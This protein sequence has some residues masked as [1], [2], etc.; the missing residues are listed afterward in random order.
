MVE[1]FPPVCG[2]NNGLLIA[3]FVGGCD[4]FGAVAFVEIPCAT[5][6]RTMTATSYRLPF[7]IYIYGKIL[8]RFAY[9]PA[10]GLAA[11][12]AS[13]HVM[14]LSWLVLRLLSDY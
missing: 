5:A 8:A 4:F 12:A 3:P 1:L 9:L 13:C 2:F 14:G 10:N 11:L 6:E 7:A